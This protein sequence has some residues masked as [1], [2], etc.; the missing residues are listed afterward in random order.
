LPV[1]EEKSVTKNPIVEVKAENPGP[2]S[3]PPLEK[4]SP[5]KTIKLGD[6]LKTDPKKDDGHSGNAS[7]AIDQPFTEEQLRAVWIEYA[8]QRKKFQAEFQMLSQPF[9][10]RNN[11]QV[12]VS[13]L[14]HV[15]DTML[16]NIKA[17]LSAFLRERLKN[18]TI[19]VMGELRSSGDDD[20]KVY[21]TARDKF[22]YL[23]AKNPLLQELKDRLGLDTDF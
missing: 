15:H 21:Y 7:K 10:L 14:S 17:E 3:A 19:Q 4:K 22:D 12:V 2:A 5:S 16:N 18:N 23:T 20:K 13:L 8:E 11:H 6:L 9:E 1:V